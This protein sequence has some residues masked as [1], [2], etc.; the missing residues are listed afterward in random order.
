MLVRSS[1]RSLTVRQILSGT[2]DTIKWPVLQLHKGACTGT[3]PRDCSP[4]SY[5]GPP[6]ASRPPELPPSAGTGSE[7]SKEPGQSSSPPSAGE[8]A[9]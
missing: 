4:N 2:A 3:A 5:P 8:V 1:S 9:A 6:K 7:A